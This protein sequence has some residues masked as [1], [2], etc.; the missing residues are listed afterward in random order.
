MLNARKKNLSKRENM[1]ENLF[2]NDKKN[3]KFFH[4]FMNV[5]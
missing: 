1:N 2:L 4:F 5:R 3:G